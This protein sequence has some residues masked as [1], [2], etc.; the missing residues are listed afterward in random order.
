VPF[1]LRRRFRRNHRHRSFGEKAGSGPAADGAGTRDMAS[2]RAAVTARSTCSGQVS[3]RTRVEFADR[4]G[5]TGR[6]V[7]RTTTRTDLSAATGDATREVLWPGR[8]GRSSEA[9]RWPSRSHG[10]GSSGPA[11]GDGSPQP[12]RTS[13]C[14]NRSRGPWRPRPARRPC[15]SDQ[16]GRSRVIG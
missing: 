3:D 8:R 10:S 7:A 2:I 5:P 9:R 1:P 16:T 14:A 13:L 11:Q 12:R 15:F 6:P 4:F